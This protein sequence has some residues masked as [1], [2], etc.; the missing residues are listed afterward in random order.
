MEDTTPPPT[1]TQFINTTAPAA[2]PPQTPRIIVATVAI[3]A[4]SLAVEVLVPEQTLGRPS[5]TQET[6]YSPYPDVRIIIPPG[7]W[8]T[9]SRRSDSDAM[10]FTVFARI[11]GADQT[12]SCGPLIRI[13]PDDKQ[14]AA[15][16]LVSLPAST[17]PDPPAPYRLTADG[18]TP[19]EQTPPP[20][21]ASTAIW[22]RLHALGTHAALQ[23]ETS[24]AQRHI[25]WSIAAAAS[26]GVMLAFVLYTYRRAPHRKPTVAP[27][28][29]RRASGASSPRLCFVDIEHA[30]RPP[31]SAAASPRADFVTLASRRW[32]G[33]A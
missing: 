31:L 26:L 1:Q 14:L 11:I 4:L 9:A 21:P 7:A 6:I 25:A 23:P 18:W 12:R 13:G 22:A 17:C 27:D 32:Q 30:P 10:T 24:N 20:K 2:A 33:S 15:P 3:G 16:I 28:R 29:T 5:P 19:V 8:G